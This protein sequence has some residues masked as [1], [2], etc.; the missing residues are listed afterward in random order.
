[1]NKKEII[2]IGCALM[3]MAII[4]LVRGAIIVR[5]NAPRPQFDIVAL[6]AGVIFGLVFLAYFIYLRKKNNKKD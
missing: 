2:I 3:V 4:G 1:M 6:V 5:S